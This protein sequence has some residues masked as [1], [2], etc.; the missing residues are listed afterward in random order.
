VDGRLSP[1]ASP[2]L[3]G[4]VNVTPDSFSDGGLYLDPTAAVAHALDLYDQGADWVDVGGESTRPGSDGV[5]AAEERHRV[6]PVIR[7]IVASRPAAAVS[8][9]TSKAEVAAAAIEA[10]AR[11]VNDVSALSDPAMGP[12]CAGA[13]VEVVLMHMRGTPGSMQRDTHYDDLVAEVVGYRG[14][15]VWDRSRPDGTPQKLLD[16][17]R[18]NALGWFPKTDLRKGIERTY[19]WYQTA[20]SD[21][22]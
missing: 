22:L 2:Q 4:V 3:M 11:M 13:D 20:V 12:L 18:L 1:V 21:S 14:K 16:L 10:G 9:D 15:I 17:S 19:R 5:D 7:G 6:V 8:V